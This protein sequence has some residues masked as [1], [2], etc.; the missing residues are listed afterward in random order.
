LLEPQSLASE[1][2]DRAR[3]DTFLEVFTD[4][5]IEFELLVEVFFDRN[6]GSIVGRGRFGRREEGEEGFGRDSL[7]DDSGLVGV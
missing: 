6:V 2:V 3:N 5:V 4:L 7:L 1:E